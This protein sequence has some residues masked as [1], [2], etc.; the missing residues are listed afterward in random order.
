[1][2]KELEKVHRAFERPRRA[3]QR[4]PTLF[5][6]LVAGGAVMVFYGFQRI[7]DEIPFLYNHPFI[8]FFLG[9]AILV[10]TGKLYKKLDH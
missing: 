1:M 3:L 4:F 10:F 6:L 8:M 7:F 9:I 5:L 2:E